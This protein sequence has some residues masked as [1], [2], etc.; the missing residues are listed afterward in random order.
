MPYRRAR[1]FRQWFFE[2]FAPNSNMPFEPLPLTDAEKQDRA[3][4]ERVA[5]KQRAQKDMTR[6]GLGNDTD[7]S[8]PRH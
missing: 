4:R 2:V 6:L 7:Q 3:E 5:V 8:G 1:S